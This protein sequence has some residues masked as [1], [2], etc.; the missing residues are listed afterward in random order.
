M[1][2]TECPLLCPICG[3]ESKEPAKESRL[4]IHIM[5]GHTSD[6]VN[7]AVDSGKLIEDTVRNR[8]SI[9]INNN[10]LRK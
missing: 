5:H 3:W 1:K 8:F 4:S 10:N 7:A 2:T 9:P 6:D